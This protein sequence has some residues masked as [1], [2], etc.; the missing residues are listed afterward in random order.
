MKTMMNWRGNR[1]TDRGKRVREKPKIRWQYLGLK[2]P[3]EESQSPSMAEIRR[4]V[5]TLSSR[6]LGQAAR[7]RPIA[8]SRPA[9]GESTHGDPGRTKRRGATE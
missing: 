8:P 1:K 5:V 4:Q 3:A 9:N 7:S 2:D 6:G